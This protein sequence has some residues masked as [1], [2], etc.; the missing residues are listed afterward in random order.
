MTMWDSLFRLVFGST[1]K[2]APAEK[3]TPQPAPPPTPTPTEPPPPP[4]PPAV[5]P[6]PPPTPE[7]APEPAP[8]PPPPEQPQP[9]AA[10]VATIELGCVDADVDDQRCGAFLGEVERTTRVRLADIRDTPDKVV[11]KRL[12]PAPQ[13]AMTI[14]QVQHALSALGFF[15][16]GKVDGICGYRT[17]SAIRLFQEYVRTMEGHQDMVPDGKLGPRTAA[18]VQRW[19]NSGQRPDWRQTPGEYDSWLGL[20][21]RVK[22]NYIAEPGPLTQKINAFES[23]SDTLKPADWDV[24]GPGNIHLIGVRRTQFTNKFDDIFVLLMKGLVFKFQGSTEPG[25]SEHPEG[26]PFLV[27]GQH[28]YHFG[29]H[30]RSYL[31][32]R[33]LG[34]GVLVI[35]AGADGRLDL[36]D[37]DKP[38]QPNATINIHWGGRG[39]AGDVNNWSEGCQVINGSVYLNPAGEIVSCQNFAAVRSGEPQTPGSG[40]TRGAYN[41]LVDL[42]TA[43]SG[44]MPSNTVRY[45]LLK[46]PDLALAP[47]LEQALNA[48]RA[49]VQEMAT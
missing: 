46:E 36:A 3:P 16:S 48:A 9:P 13:G 24:T 35:R 14:A 37:I 32:L 34:P 47:D 15:P 41:V 10:P 42:V 31:A 30:Q 44:D 28:K 5:P 39:M 17:Q 12:P 27:P 4:P 23:A 11:T 33:P 6:P 18:H 25:H 40:K 1:R 45:T 8:P 26:P 29:W 43:L 20:L 49:R 7:P 2:G 38:L 19:L 22:Q 21:D